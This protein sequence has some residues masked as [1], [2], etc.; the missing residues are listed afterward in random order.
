MLVATVSAAN[1]KPMV[2]LPASCVI[3][4]YRDMSSI[5]LKQVARHVLGPPT[6][7]KASPLRSLVLR[8][9]PVALAN[10]RRHRR[11]RRETV[12]VPI[13]P[14]V[15]SKRLVLLRV[16][17]ALL[18]QR[19]L[20]EQKEPHQAKPLIVLAAIATV[21]NIK[22]KVASLARLVRRGALA[23]WEKK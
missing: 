18:M 21:A 2:L 20:L 9:P 4:V 8:G 6:K 3:I 7:H 19:V 22:V 13:A 23:R 5:L 17:L 14:V 1:T 10:I 11:H 12:V 15:N 16:P